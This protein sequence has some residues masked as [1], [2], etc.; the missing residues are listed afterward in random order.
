MVE[1]ASKLKVI[2]RQLAAEVRTIKA[3]LKGA[4][5]ASLQQERQTREQI[6]TLRAEALDLQKH[7]IQYNILKR[8]VETNRLLY[9]GLLQRFKEVEVAGGV[10]MSTIHVV[11]DARISDAASNSTP[12]RTVAIWLAL[13]LAA[14]VASALALDR[15]DDRVRSSRQVE[16]LTGLP[17]LGII[18]EPAD[19]TAELALCDPASPLTEAYR[20][21]AATLESMS[22]IGLPR[23]VLITSASA[24]EGKSLTALAIA[25]HYATLGRRI[26]LI[27]ADLRNPSLH[28]KLDLSHDIGL[29]SYLR[30]DCGPLDAMQATGLA[31]LA[32]MA[33]GPSSSHVADLLAGPR[34]DP[35][36]RGGTSLFDLIVIDG[37][38]VA[39][40]ADAA[41]LASAAS[42]TVVVVASGQTRAGLLQSALRR[43]DLANARM[44]G[45]VL[46]KVATSA[47]DYGDRRPRYPSKVAAALTVIPSTASSRASQR[48]LG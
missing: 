40:L 1:I 7:M 25:R 24:A 27:D 30:G 18:G 32:F 42:A 19:T 37:P 17:T 38:P 8:D 35:L 22:G 39:H 36:L 13:G 2:D 16:R 43:L 26:L 23:S 11:D 41:I 29:S 20:A 45:A 9:N 44:V 4:Y 15:A 31:N 48:R 12:L 21:F 46:T 3:S 6:E 5:E 14:G 34:L 47:V 33:S 10:G 28:I